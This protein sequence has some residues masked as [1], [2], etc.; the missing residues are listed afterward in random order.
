MKGGDVKGADL[1]SY[2]VKS[3]VSQETPQRETGDKLEL[4]AWLRLLGAVNRVEGALRGRMRQAFDSTLPRF[5]MLAQLA[6]VPAGLSMGDLS[7]RLMVSNGNVTDVMARLEKDGLVRRAP[8]PADRRTVK[9]RLTGRGEKAFREMAEP[10]G[11]W[12]A[13]MFSGLSREEMVTL[14]AL[15]DRLRA[16]LEQPEAPG[17]A[18]SSGETPA[19]GERAP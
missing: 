10:H 11:A 8:S 13:R 9:A 1:K 6:R 17:T 12:I 2:A 5:D 4:R 16:S 15:M 3:P 14:I 7:R 19:E 18:G